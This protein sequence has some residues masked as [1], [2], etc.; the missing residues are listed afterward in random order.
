MRSFTVV[1]ALLAL[2]LGLG[3]VARGEDGAED[4]VAKLE[5][6]VALLEAQVEYLTAREDAVTAYLLAATERSKALRANLARSRDEGFTQ[7]AI[8]STSREYLLGGLEGYAA[9]VA[10]DLP[11]L[12]EVQVQLRRQIENLKRK[13]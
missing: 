12:T 13:R 1:F 10:R 3:V 4:K 11:D 2:V 5:R 9:D 6:H 7:A 8:S